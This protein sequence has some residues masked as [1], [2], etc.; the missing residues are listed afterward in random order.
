MPAKKDL[1]STLQRSRK[2]AQE[3][4]AK[5]YDSAVQQYGEGER[6][7]RTAYSALK[8]THEKVGDHWEEKDHKGPSDPQAAQS[9]RA[10]R[11]RPRSTYGGVDG[12]ATRLTRSR[13]PPGWRSAVV[14]GCPSRS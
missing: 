3:T 10:S 8:H 14:A 6:A 4:W 13:S 7:H 12:N 5:T 11:E 1:P 2:K 9:G